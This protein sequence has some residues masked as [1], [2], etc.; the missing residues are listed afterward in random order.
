MKLPEAQ[1]TEAQSEQDETVK[2]L[3]AQD[4]DAQSKQDETVKV[5]EAQDTE[6]QSEQD[7]T[8]KLPEAQD[9]NFETETT[10]FTE[11]TKD[12]AETSTQV[13]NAATGG[14]QEHTV[15]EV[16]G[17]GLKD[18]SQRPEAASESVG[19]AYET[20]EYSV[21]ET[22]KESITNDIREGQGL[23]K[24]DEELAKN[25]VSYAEQVQGSQIVA[26]QTET[27]QQPEEL[28]QSVQQD[29]TSVPVEAEGASVLTFPSSNEI[30]KQ[31]SGMTIAEGD[32]AETQ[33]IQQSPGGLHA[34]DA[35]EALPALPL[36]SQNIRQMQGITSVP[37]NVK[38]YVTEQNRAPEIR[39]ALPVISQQASV[40]ER[41][42]APLEIQPSIYSPLKQFSEEQLKMFYFN[43]E[44]EQVS[45]FIDEFLK[46]S[47]KC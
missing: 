27:E 16:N 31:A 18:G 4:T 6:A 20:Q 32:T 25:D 42:A 5:L 39:T 13:E 30:L 15:V 46:V 37:E 12:Q 38:T 14:L 43:P 11:H 41:I 21:R 9:D 45:M 2:L 33:V 29:I 28:N 8:V 35:A 19:D 24:A 47:T 34:E 36:S 23:P 1:D 3:E 26:Q 17:V 40:Q 44:L 10:N 22:E 7:E